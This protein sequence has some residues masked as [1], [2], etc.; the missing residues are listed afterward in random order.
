MPWWSSPAGKTFQYWTTFYT[1]SEARTFTDGRKD[2]YHLTTAGELYLYAVWICDE[3]D[4]YYS[5]AA[6]S[7]F[8]D[9][10]L[11]VGYN[12]SV[13]L[14]TIEEI[15]EISATAAE[16]FAAPE[17][18]TFAGWSDSS[19]YPESGVLYTAGQEV[20][21]LTKDGVIVLYAVWT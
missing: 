15:R 17:G 3:Y 21:Q 8:M 14:K 4:I 12:A 11:G 5:T 1:D 13:T 6:G 16:A 7:N 19:N 18:K 9:T 10:E 2:I 20:S